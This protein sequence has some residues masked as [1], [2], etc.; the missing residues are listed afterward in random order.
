L[1]PEPGRELF[2]SQIGSWLIQKQL[3]LDSQ[4]RPTYT[5]APM[6]YQLSIPVVNLLYNEKIIPRGKNIAAIYLKCSFSL[7]LFFTFV[8]ISIILS[9][10]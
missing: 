5:A 9:L 10:L 4:L 2:E 6:Y 7:K 8:L 3:V 1:D